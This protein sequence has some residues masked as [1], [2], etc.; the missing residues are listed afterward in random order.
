MR[1]TF[2]VGRNIIL[3]HQVIPHGTGLTDVLPDLYQFAHH[4]RSYKDRRVVYGC[5]RR[6]N[7]K[8]TKKNIRKGEQASVMMAQ[9]RRNKGRNG[10]GQNIHWA[11]RV[12][13]L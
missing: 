2:H 3:L 7:E 4:L 8:T 11:P 6:I 1:E 9:T 10:V 13:Y 12:A 5:F